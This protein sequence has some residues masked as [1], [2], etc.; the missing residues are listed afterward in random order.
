MPTKPV[1]KKPIPGKPQA[2]KPAQKNVVQNKPAPGKI[3]GLRLLKE[4]PQSSPVQKKPTPKPVR[5]KVENLAKEYLAELKEVDVTFEKGTA[6]LEKYRTKYPELVSYIREIVPGDLRIEIRQRLAG[7]DINLHLFAI[8]VLEDE[9]RYEVKLSGDA[10]S[11]FCSPRRQPSSTSAK[12]PA[13]STS[14]PSPV[15]S[16][17]RTARFTPAPRPRLTPSPA[18]SPA[19]SARRRSESTPSI[20]AWSRLKAPTAAASSDLIS[21][22]APSRRLRSA[23]SANL[24]TSPPSLSFWR[25]KTPPGSPASNFSLPVAFANP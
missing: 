12:A 18:C 15:A 14:A 25:R 9:V 2:V 7:E 23:A 6:V 16:H 13:S 3:K 17:L 1:A 4:T 5:D 8:R 10:C 24:A 19:S 22:R 21:R 11:V 20:P